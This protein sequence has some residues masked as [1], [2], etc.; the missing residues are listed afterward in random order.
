MDEPTHNIGRFNGLRNKQQSRRLEPGDLTVASNIDVD[1]TGGI[2]LRPGFIKSLDLTS[3]T[4]AFTTH[5]ERRA[6]VVDNGNLILIHPGLSSEIIAMGMSTGYIHWV[7][8]GKFVVL[9][10][11]HIIDGM[12]NVTS[13]RIETPLQ[14]KVSVVSGN[15]PAGQYKVAVAYADLSGREGGASDI[16]TLDV[17]TDSGLTI[18]PEFLTNDRVRVYV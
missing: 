5:D 12:N 3:V 7:E 4:A 2:I 13:W 18:A 11:G 10:T 6:F 15:L 8:I 9:S 17:P 1:D 14:P 16:L